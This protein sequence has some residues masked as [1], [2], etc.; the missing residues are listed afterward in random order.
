MRWGDFKEA[1]QSTSGSSAG[2]VFSC[3]VL[4]DGIVPTKVEWAVDGRTVS[5]QDLNQVPK[6]D[7]GEG[8]GSLQAPA[9]TAAPMLF[10]IA[11]R[12]FRP[13]CGHLKLMR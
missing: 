12:W 9:L 4:Y 3:R 10:T 5:V 13:Q 2:S 8:Q 7:G 1:E 6:R 11:L